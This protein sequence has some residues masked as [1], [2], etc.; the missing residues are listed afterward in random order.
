MPKYHVTK[1]RGKAKIKVKEKRQAAMSK[2]L[3]SY[4]EEQ[5]ITIALIQELVPLGLKAVS[6]E[7]PRE[8]QELTGKRYQH[9][10]EASR[11]GFQPGAVYLRDQKL[12]IMVPRVRDSKA[13]QEIRLASYEKLQRPN[14]YE[15]CQISTKKCIDSLLNKLI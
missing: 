15:P 11:W 2:I 6:E 7:L 10:A 13:N 9:G 5:D 1:S 4:S 14:F 12:P 3:K 8:V